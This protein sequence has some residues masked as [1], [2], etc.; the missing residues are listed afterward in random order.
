LEAARV[1]QE[2]VDRGIIDTELLLTDADLALA[3]GDFHRCRERLQQL[4][5]H[6][7]SATEQSRWEDL[8]DRCL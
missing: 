4:Q 6:R 7:L 5:G 1:L 3:G 8:H 2:A